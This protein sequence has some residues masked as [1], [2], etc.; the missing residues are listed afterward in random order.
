MAALDRIQ[1]HGFRRWYE[2]QL[3][4]CHAWLVT[5]FL[6]I[7]ATASGIEIFGGSAPG[8]RVAGGSLILGGIIVGLLS[9]QYYRRMLDV[10]E[11]FGELAICS[12]CGTYGRFAV[13]ASGPRPLP[14]GAD[15]MLDGSAGEVWL[16][17]RCRKCANEWLIA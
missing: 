16:R 14:D 6:G 13:L 11:R 1:S 2:R 15:P 12:G 17:V 8:G 9:W 4:E 5:C 7:I 10:A 3:I